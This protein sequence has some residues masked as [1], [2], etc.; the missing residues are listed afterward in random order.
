[1]HDQSLSY[2]T[3]QTEIGNLAKNHLEIMFFGT[4]TQQ[5]QNLTTARQAAPLRNTNSPCKLEPHT[6]PNLLLHTSGL[7]TSEGACCRA[8]NQ[9]VGKTVLA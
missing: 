5:Q 8:D 2:Q 6:M 7:F 1:L 9:T 3:K 4:N